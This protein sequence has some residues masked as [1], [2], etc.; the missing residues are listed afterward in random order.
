MATLVLSVCVV[1]VGC[2]FLARESRARKKGTRRLL[3]RL[4]HLGTR[5]G[6]HFSA[7][8]VWPRCIIGLDGPNRKLLAIRGPLEAGRISVID[9]DSATSCKLIG[10]DNVPQHLPVTIEMRFADEDGH[11][12][13]QITLFTS[14]DDVDDY[15]QAATSAMDWE[16]ML[17]KLIVRHEVTEKKDR[18]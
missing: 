7:Q 5:H 4:S 11:L 13:E 17:S 8:Q 18:N 12:M 14:D 6:L 3:D 2:V 9:L 15:H 16:A 1:I 10:A